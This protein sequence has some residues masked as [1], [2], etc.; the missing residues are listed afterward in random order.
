MHIK[1]VVETEA[2]MVEFTAELSPVQHAFLLEYA[3]RDLVKK[4]LIPFINIEN[5]KELAKVAPNPNEN[6]LN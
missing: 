3:V 1:T 2:G 5:E 4:G 6:T